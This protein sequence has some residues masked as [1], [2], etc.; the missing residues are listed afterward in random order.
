MNILTLLPTILTLVEVIKRFIPD[1]QRNVANPVIA[2]GLGLLGAY[3]TN[4]W[5]GILELLKTG[6]ISGI[7]AI[8]VYKIPKEIAAKLTIGG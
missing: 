4:E 8:A 7:G 6:L 3:A 1:K 2:V 5:H